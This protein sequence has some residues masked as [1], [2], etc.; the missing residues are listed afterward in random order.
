MDDAERTFYSALNEYLQDGFALAKRQGG[1]GVALGFV[2]TIFQKIAASSFAAVAR[3]LRPVSYTHLDVYK[4]QKRFSLNMSEICAYWNCSLAF[5]SRS[6]PLS[7]GLWNGSSSSMQE[8][9]LI[10]I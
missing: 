1:K 9:S 5:G 7:R 6:I 2:M 8:L 10:H 4:R 3:T